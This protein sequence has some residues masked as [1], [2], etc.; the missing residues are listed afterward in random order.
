MEQVCITYNVYV[1]VVSNGRRVYFPSSGPP[2]Q[3]GGDPRESV[4][5]A[6]VTSADSFVAGGAT[7]TSSLLARSA[8]REYAPAFAPSSSR[9]FRDLSSP[10]LSPASG[11]FQWTSHATTA[12]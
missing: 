12:R 5:Q 2:R 7:S 9:P 3:S 8:S 4:G 11:F 6:G 10:S 1:D